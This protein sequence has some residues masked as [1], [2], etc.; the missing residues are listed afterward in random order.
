MNKYWIFCFSTIIIML[1]SSC[2]KSANENNN[3]ESD[4]TN[5]PVITSIHFYPEPDIEEKPFGYGYIQESDK[6]NPVITPTS[7]DS[8]ENPVITP[9][10]EEKVYL[11]LTEDEILNM[12]DEDLWYYADLEA[13]HLLGNSLSYPDNPMKSV[14]EDLKKRFDKNYP[15]SLSV[16]SS[17]ALDYADAV[18]IAETVF[19]SNGNMGYYLNI[20]YIG[21]YDGFYVFAANYYYEKK[22]SHIVG[23]IIYKK[24]YFDF[25]TKTL[26]C[27]LN[28][29]N[30][31]RFLKAYL[32]HN[33]YGIGGYF[34]ETDEGYCFRIYSIGCILGDWNMHDRAYLERTECIVSKDGTLSFTEADERIRE[35]DIPYRYNSYPSFE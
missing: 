33:L 8:K 25:E 30:V 10:S 2:N 20:Q 22:F 28:H 23:E 31:F 35:S 18:R 26:K 12:S 11:D 29:D 3:N 14:F 21:E 16:S 9:A 17:S 7:E 24:D 1:F 15:K 19:P 32:Y 4:I 34:S 6:E 5:T 13:K 27:E